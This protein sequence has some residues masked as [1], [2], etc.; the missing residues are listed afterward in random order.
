MKVAYVGRSDV[1]S[2]AA[3]DLKPH[4]VEGFRKTEFKRGET[5]EV[6]D[7]VGKVLIEDSGT[8]GSFKE[9]TSEEEETDLVKQAEALEKSAEQTPSN[10]GAASTAGGTGRRTTTRSTGT[11]GTGTVAGSTARS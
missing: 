7:A 4:G 6:D 11:T 8:F 10:E 2:L 5:V 1:R 9:V 3:E